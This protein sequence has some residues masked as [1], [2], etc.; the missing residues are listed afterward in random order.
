MKLLHAQ[1]GE[2]RRACDELRGLLPPADLSTS[3]RLDRLDLEVTGQRLNRT[4]RCRG[5]SASPPS[6][7]LSAP[8]AW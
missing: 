8:G 7:T 3:C 4:V 2:P 1:L 5:E 6:R